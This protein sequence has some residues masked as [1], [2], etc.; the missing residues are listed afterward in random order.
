[1]LNGDAVFPHGVAIVMYYNG[2]QFKLQPVRRLRN[3]QDLSC[4][5][6]FSNKLANSEQKMVAS[7]PTTPE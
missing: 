6:R 2:D 1:M 3:I 7:S 4:V 5:R